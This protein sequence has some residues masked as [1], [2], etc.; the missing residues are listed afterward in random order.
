MVNHRHLPNPTQ[1]LLLQAALS[2][3]DTA[4][5]AWREWQV[6][7]RWETDAIDEASLRMLPLVYSSLTRIDPLLPGLVRLKGWYRRSWLENTRLLHQTRP[8]IQ[9]LLDAG[10][11]VMILKGTSL[12]VRYYKDRGA[13]SM[14]DIDLL[15]PDSEAAAALEIL[16][17]LGWTSNERDNAARDVLAR[18][19]GVNLAHPDGGRIDLHR[20]LLA[21]SPRNADGPLWEHAVPVVLGDS[22][23]VAPCN[24][25]ELLLVCVHGWQ[26]Q[27][28][29]SIRWIH[30]A[31]TIAR[32][33]KEDDWQRLVNEARR[34]Q[35][36]LRMSLAI[37]VIRERFGTAVPDRV[38]AQLGTTPVADFEA[39]EERNHTSPPGLLPPGLMRAYFAHTR[40]VGSPDGAGW[41]IGCARRFWFVS[42]APSVRTLAPWLVRWAR[43]RVNAG[44]AARQ[45][46]RS[47]V[48][49]EHRAPTPAPSALQPPI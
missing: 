11:R 16:E 39:A 13:R 45:V 43:R 18:H 47:A 40:E 25:D 2:D 42:N 37:G 4:C 29:P 19:H 48:R 22:H 17:R 31:V 20:R 27:P 9:A 7:T 49:T 8:S 44:R 6:R 38:L 3:G 23:V 32:H 5:G 14:R 46:P 21:D 30:D 34:R 36:S 12:T 41:W 1:E 33:M 10:L 24:A 35:V 15:V 26:W 28:V